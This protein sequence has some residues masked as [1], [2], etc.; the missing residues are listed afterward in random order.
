MGSQWSPAQTA[1]HVGVL[2]AWS[3][4]LLAWVLLLPAMPLRAFGPA[5]APVQSWGTLATRAVRGGALA[6]L[7]QALL[8]ATVRIRQVSGRRKAFPKGVALL[9]ALVAPID[10]HIGAVVAAVAVG[11]VFAALVS[12]DWSLWEQQGACSWED[13]VDRRAAV[14]GFL[15]SFCFFW[16][17]R[18]QLVF[19]PVQQ[20]RL[21]RV[22]NAVPGMILNSLTG[23][24]SG[25]V[26]VEL[27]ESR[28]FALN[29]ECFKGNPVLASMLGFLVML[30]VE[31]CMFLTE[32]V[33]EILLTE[34][35]HVGL[36]NL[37]ALSAED[38]VQLL[39]SGLDL[40]D[41]ASLVEAMQSFPIHFV[42]D[43]EAYREFCRSGFAGSQAKA[44][45]LL[46]FAKVCEIE[47]N[48]SAQHH[49]DRDAIVV[50][51]RSELHKWWMTTCEAFVFRDNSF[52]P[53]E[54]M[55]VLRERRHRSVLQAIYTAD[56]HSE[57]FAFRQRERLS[58]HSEITRVRSFFSLLSLSEFDEEKRHAILQKTSW[59]FH[60]VD[61][62]ICNIDSL[63]LSV[64]VATKFSALYPSS[65]RGSDGQSLLDVLVLGPPPGERGMYDPRLKDLAWEAES[66][67][68]GI[69]N[70]SWWVAEL[71]NQFLEYDPVQMQV[72][73]EKQLR[74]YASSNGG[75]VGKDHYEA[76]R[77]TWEAQWER[78]Q[79][80]KSSTWLVW[81]K[82]IVF[83]APEDQTMS[84]LENAQVVSCCCLALSNFVKNAVADGL[85]DRISVTIPTILHSL[86]ECYVALKE[87]HASPAFRGSFDPLLEMQG[88]PQNRKEFNMIRA[89]IKSS[90]YAIVAAYGDRLASI[91]FP[92]KLEEA[93]LEFSSCS[94]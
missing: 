52:E 81:L 11:R 30:V 55:Q 34:T 90:I 7:A 54:Q 39:I 67:S 6:G 93:L 63:T 51:A 91:S 5:S 17:S 76:K 41:G 40:S 21:A 12:D 77:E 86:L 42:A 48:K 3:L 35:K 68:R 50:M 87:Y 23:A 4:P 14:A 94:N 29:E 43:D 37:A 78:Q 70:R 82:S 20:K 25:I 61:S 62:C 47:A 27:M 73:L 69:R 64:M 57:G 60:V 49:W 9:R 88:P 32:E 19:P 59:W 56:A 83:R 24:L 75:V 46:E 15:H 8:Q 10:A 33:A 74:T 26:L 13:M 36:S 28:A 22:R 65:L 80:M 16:A 79:K 58:A 53:W 2:W 44:S 45:R 31:L 84:L 71:L 66:R 18:E 1:L 85:E 89:S 72:Q 38:E 92:E